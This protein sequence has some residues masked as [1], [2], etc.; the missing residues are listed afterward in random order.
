MHNMYCAL[1]AL[2]PS[3][4][5]YSRSIALYM[6]IPFN[7]MLSFSSTLLVLLFLSLSIFLL[8]TSTYYICCIY[9]IYIMHICTLSVWITVFIVSPFWLYIFVHKFIYFSQK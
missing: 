2:F 6:N 1:P 8:L 4:S 9:I 5:L 3:L 7:F